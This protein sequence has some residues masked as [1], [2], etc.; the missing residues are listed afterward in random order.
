MINNFITIFDKIDNIP[1]HIMLEPFIRQIQVSDSTT[2]SYNIFDFN[3]FSFVAKND[4]LQIK[5]AIQL[6]DL[7]AK[8]YLNNIVFA[9]MSADPILNII[10][11]NIDN[12]TM[13]EFVVKFIKISLAMY[14]ASEKKKKPKEKILPLYNN[15]SVTK[16]QAGITP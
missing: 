15:R 4:K 8:V 12:E 16:N 10:R 14:Y 9:Q 11:R 1:M 3:F 13:H 2:F 5:N 6:L 7:L